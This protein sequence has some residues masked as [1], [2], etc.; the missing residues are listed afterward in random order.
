MKTISLILLIPLFT[1]C[2]INRTKEEPVSNLNSQNLSLAQ[3]EMTTSIS[4]NLSERLILATLQGNANEVRV[5]LKSKNL[6]INYRNSDGDAS[7]HHATGF[8]SADDL[9]NETPVGNIAIVKLLIQNNADINIPNRRGDSPLLNASMF[10][11]YE[12]AKFLI[13]SG[14]NVKFKNAQENTALHNAVHCP[15]KI[16][17]L[18]LNNNVNLNDKNSDGKSPLDCAKEFSNK[19]VI[20]HL[21]SKGAK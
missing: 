8:I 7:I 13:D 17:K 15:L 2:A 5:L 20:S 11:Q 3:N 19:E 21:I 12:I 16:V 6:N 10:C 9:G 1:F 14:A 18:L 4:N